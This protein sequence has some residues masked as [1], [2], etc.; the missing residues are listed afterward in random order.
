MPRFDGR[1]WISVAF[2][3]G[4]LF[5]LFLC[6]FTGKHSVPLLPELT[7]K[8]KTTAVTTLRPQVPPANPRPGISEVLGVAKVPKGRN[9]STLSELL[10]KVQVNGVVVATTADSG[11]LYL[12]V[13]WICH[14]QK[15]GLDQNVIVFALDEGMYKEM[16][17]R[18]GF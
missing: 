9:G 16:Q 7:G 11:Y 1:S 10:A 5:A 6:N 17:A 12:T 14:L 2:G 13:N 8:V 15:L 18:G 4:F 3:V